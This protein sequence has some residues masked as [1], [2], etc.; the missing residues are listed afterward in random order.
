M[1][2]IFFVIV[3]VISIYNIYYTNKMSLIDLRRYKKDISYINNVSNVI[4]EYE[5][6]NKIEVKTIFYRYDSDRAYYYYDLGN[7]NDLTIRLAAVD[8]AMNCAINCYNNRKIEYKSMN[9]ADY[10]KY[11]EGK[12]YDEFNKEQIK[13]FENEVYLLIY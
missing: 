7:G 11:F 1:V 5:N 6:K 8:W 2:K 3:A 4:L 13:F 10:I 12:E 9:D